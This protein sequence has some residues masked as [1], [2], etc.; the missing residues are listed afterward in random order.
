MFG[1]MAGDQADVGELIDGQR[2]RVQGNVRISRGRHGI[3]QGRRRHHGANDKN[4][5]FNG[6]DPWVRKGDP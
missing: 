3:G 2:R 4:W 1:L 5:C 6:V